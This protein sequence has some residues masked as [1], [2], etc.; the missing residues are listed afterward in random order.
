MLTFSF[1]L[2]KSFYNLHQGFKGA[3]GSPGL[4]GKPGIKGSPGQDGDTG[5]MGDVGAPGE[6]G[7]EGLPGA[8]GGLGARGF[9]GRQGELGGSVSV[10]TIGCCSFKMDCT[11]D[12]YRPSQNKT[13]FAYCCLSDRILKNQQRISEAFA[14]YKVE[15]SCVRYNGKDL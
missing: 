12:T 10:S 2:P 13:H 7:S 8:D 5:P 9:A 11:D 1:F 4:P 6:T 14:S 15:W 3:T